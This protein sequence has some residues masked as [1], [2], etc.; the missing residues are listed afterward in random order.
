MAQ[1]PE[2]M[3]HITPQS[4]YGSDKDNNTC[5]IPS[6]FHDCW[7]TVFE[8]L[9]P[10]EQVEFVQEFNRLCREKDEVDGRDIHDLQELIKEKNRRWSTDGT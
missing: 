9:T 8:N 7:H 5:K 1:G 6:N 10:E 4:R 3:H 2:E